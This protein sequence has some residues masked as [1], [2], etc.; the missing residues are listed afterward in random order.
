MDKHQDID[1]T[2]LDI[3]NTIIKSRK[4]NIVLINDNLFS[5]EHICV[6]VV[7]RQF[8]LDLQEK[9]PY[10]LH[11]RNIIS[12]TNAY[13]SNN[14]EMILRENEVFEKEY[15]NNFR[16]HPFT[17]YL[18]LANISKNC[19][20]I[21]RSLLANDFIESESGSLATLNKWLIS[22]DLETYRNAINL[23]NSISEL[24]ME[25]INI[26]ELLKLNNQS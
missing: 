16:L 3:K 5:I 7:L 12:L 10:T 22:T 15:D 4:Q 20:E 8:I 19:L 18:K 14:I 25:I 9:K 6:V 13:A 23:I 11:I 17:Y 21:L 2:T 1:Y 26:E 24:D